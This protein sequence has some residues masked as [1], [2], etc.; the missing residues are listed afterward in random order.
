[1]IHLVLGGCRSGKSRFA[2][3]TLLAALANAPHRHCHYVATA[4]GL[5]DEMRQRIERHQQDRQATGI[6]WHNHEV[7]T[8]LTATLTALNHKEYLVLVDCLTLWLTGWLCD[9]PDDY[10]PAKQQLL[11]AITEFTGHLVLVSNEVGSGIVPLGELSRRF[12][13]EAGWLNQAIAQQ[14]D[15]VTLV[16]AG[17]PLVLK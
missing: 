14:A 6:P 5:D 17:L 15:K 2:E 1:M 11:A 10:L 7:G 16:V 4:L 9:A 13:D 8:E 12:S 3:Q